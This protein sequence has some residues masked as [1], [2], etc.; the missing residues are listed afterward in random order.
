LELSDN[1]RLLDGPVTDA[2]RELTDTV[3]EDTRPVCQ[4]AMITFIRFQPVPDWSA[5]CVKESTAQ[6][7]GGAA[8]V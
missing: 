4:G 8:Y 2:P 3:E 6:E 1:E 5:E 7:V